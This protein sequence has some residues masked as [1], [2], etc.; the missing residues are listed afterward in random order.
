MK[1]LSLGVSTVKISLDLDREVL[2][3]HMA[4]QT[5]LRYLN[6]D[7]DILI[8]ETSFLKVSRFS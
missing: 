8:V 2:H 1:K 5:K 4:I 3:L 7:R 6:L